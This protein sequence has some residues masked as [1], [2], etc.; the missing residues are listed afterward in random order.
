MYYT[1]EYSNEIFDTLEECETDLEETIDADEYAWRISIDELVRKYFRRKS[2]EE[3]CN[4]LDDKICEID[5]E[6][7][8][9]LIFEHEEESEE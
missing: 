1:H 4:W 7:K 5:E 9:D 6:I 3:F 8:N 2:N